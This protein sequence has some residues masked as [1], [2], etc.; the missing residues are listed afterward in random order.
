MLKTAAHP[1]TDAKVRFLPPVKLAFVSVRGPYSRSVGEAWS[2][3]FD[4]LE[5]RGHMESPGTG[6]GLAHDD[7]QTTLSSKIRYD[8]GVPIPA[9]WRDGDEEFAHLRTFKGG[10]YTVQRYVGPYTNIGGMV[11]A[12]R[13]E[14]LPRTGLVLDKSRPLLCIYY[15]DPRLIGPAEQQTDVCLPVMTERRAKPR[16]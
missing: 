16:D 10:S 12:T 7:P 2:H 4:W 3:M 8:A 13:R 5:K 6:Y 11:S 15:S 9:T 1:T 14:L